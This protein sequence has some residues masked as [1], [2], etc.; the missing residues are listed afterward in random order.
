RV[1]AIDTA[2]SRSPV[3]IPPLLL[4]LLFRSLPRLPLFPYTTLFRSYNR[5]PNRHAVPH[6]PTSAAGVRRSPGILPLEERPAQLSLA[7]SSSSPPSSPGFLPFFLARSFCAREM[8]APR[9]SPRLAPESD[10]P[11]SLI[12]CFSS[13][14]SRALI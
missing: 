11:Y 2:H 1:H 9:I 3:H 5:F 13:S 7:S 12:A 10:E 14:T 8:A 4:L 6:T